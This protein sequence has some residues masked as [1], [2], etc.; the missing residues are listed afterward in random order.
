MT[1][2]TQVAS[3]ARRAVHTARGE[4]LRALPPGPVEPAIAQTVQW[5]AQPVPFLERAR[6]RYGETFTMHHAGLDPFVSFS[7]PEAI[8][9]IFTGP[10]DQLL[11]GQAN[12][13]LE[14][15]LGESSVLLLDGARHMS[16]RRLLLPPFHG[17]RMRAYGEPMRDVALRSIARWPRGRA[18]P[19]HTEMQGITLEV[20]LRTVF[21]V[22]GG[23]VLDELSATLTELLDRIANPIWLLRFMQVD[24]G[25]YSPGARLARML[26]RVD[27]LLFAIIRDARAADRTGREDVLSML[28]DARHEDGSPMSDRELRDELLTL[29]VAGHETT[30]TSLA[31]TFSR[32]LD[33]PDILARAVAEVGAGPVDPDRVRELAFVDAIVKETLRLNPVV[34]IVGRRLQAPLRFGGVD[35]PAGVVAVPNIYL[36]H[37]NPRVWP[38]P[39]RFD[40]S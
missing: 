30:A 27:S 40:P 26:E 18:F 5:I 3:L 11:A 31:W 22:S 13:V 38:S 16:Q 25:R 8:K 10:P 24:L 2:L 29:L 19:I 9:D 20:I 28:L 17:Q 36:T 12:A 39:D 21:G 32:L 34:P 4:R 14:P 23:P 6:E 7:D 37:R 15:I 33:H 35:L 1:V